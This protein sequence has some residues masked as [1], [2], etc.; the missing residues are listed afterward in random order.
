METP[1]FVKQFVHEE[2]KDEQPDNQYD[3]PED[4]STR[5]K[6]FMLAALT[7][8]SS[9]AIFGFGTAVWLIAHHL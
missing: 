5:V 6:L 7:I 3:W 4:H 1:N 8:Y 9:F 2:I